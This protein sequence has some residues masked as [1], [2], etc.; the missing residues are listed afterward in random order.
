M[1][2]S[3]PRLAVFFLAL[4]VAASGAAIVY[5]Y[6]WVW[7]A[8]RCESGGKWWDPYGRV[9]AQPVLISDITGRVIQDPQARAAAK[10]AVGRVDKPAPA[11]P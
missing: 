6:G 2:S 5:H 4:F 1:N 10:A 11:T 8:Q 3:I 9:C 7:P